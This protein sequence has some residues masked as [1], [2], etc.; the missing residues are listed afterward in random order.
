MADEVA[1]SDLRDFI[2]GLVSR[3]MVKPAPSKRLFPL[4]AS[5]QKKLQRGQ[6]YAA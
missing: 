3:T 4:E 6:T 5:D 2:D 1:S